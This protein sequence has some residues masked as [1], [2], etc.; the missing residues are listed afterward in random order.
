MTK[1]LLQADLAEQIRESDGP[2]ELMDD[3]GKCVGIVRRIPSGRDIETAKSRVGKTGPKF[4][5]AELI[6]KLH[7]L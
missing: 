2:I 4:T 5:V 7:Q 1:I 6:A 3:T